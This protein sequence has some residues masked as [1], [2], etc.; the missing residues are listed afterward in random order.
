METKLL[1]VRGMHCPTCP[2]LIE[3]SLSGL[4][5]LGA[6]QANLGR[7]TCEVEVLAGAFADDEALL[8]AINERVRPH[9]FRMGL[10]PF[11][12]L[13]L[14]GGWHEWLGGLALAAVVAALIFY[15]GSALHLPEATG[16]LL[17]LSLGFAA[18]LSTCLA[19]TGSIIIA[20]TANYR[21]LGETGK[22]A[23]LGVNM[24]LQA[25]RLAAFFGL[26]GLLG[27]LGASLHL[28]GNTL[29]IFY[30]VIGLLLFSLAL[31]MLGLG[32]SVF[33]LLRLP[34]S[35]TLIK[36]LQGRKSL[37]LP[38]LAGAL[39][40]FLPCGFAISMML[41]VVKSG[42]F[43]GGAVTMLLFA[44]G[45]LPV[46]L[47]VGMTASF[48]QGPGHGLLKKTVAFLVLAFAFNAF[49]TAAGYYGYAGNILDPVPS[50]ADSGQKEAGLSNL[51]R[52]TVE[53]TVTANAFKPRRI[54]I[55]PGH[56]ITWIIRGDNI[57]NCTNRLIVPELNINQ[58]IKNGETVVTFVAPDKPGPVRF[59]CW[60]AMVTGAFVV[61]NTSP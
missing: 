11:R 36:A 39:T 52:Q 10:E 33:S 12:G 47:L 17:P 29:S 55:R 1:H 34:S 54:S 13:A 41:E 50:V 22:G 6:V 24:A 42:S 5:G 31:G 35:L 58:P 9:G 40:F 2:L 38:A 53:M 25:G 23:V 16:L 28:Q 51:P 45:T 8:A 30:I 20:F 19:L 60:M 37:V 3:E 46:L 56:L 57:S 48:S 59:S 26:G 7:H 43:G 15:G 14:E 21:N 44:L 27:W 4:P 32:R 61:E 18:S 49:Y